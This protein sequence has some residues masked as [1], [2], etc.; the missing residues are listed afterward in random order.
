MVTFNWSGQAPS[1]EYSQEFIQGMLNR[2]AM[3]FFKYGKITD[4]Y[5][6]KRD[7]MATL[8]KY[9]ALYEQDGNLERL[10]DAANYLMIEFIAPKREGAVM[11]ATDSAESIGRARV[12][13][14]R[15]DQGA[16]TKQ[17][18]R[19]RRGETVA[20]QPQRPSESMPDVYKGRIGD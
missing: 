4:A 10:I 3:S 17:Q 11:R 14:G 8:K 5:P 13:D 9:I 16:N 12:G 2:M 7:A 6:S 18:E 15:F 1:T 19:V 20:A